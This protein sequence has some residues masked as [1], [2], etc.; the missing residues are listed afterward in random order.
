MKIFKY[1][2]G[3]MSIYH[4]VHFW[5][6]LKMLLIIMVSWPLT[7][8]AESDASVAAVRYTLA[9]GH[10]LRPTVKLPGTVK[11]RH[12]SIIASVSQSAQE[13]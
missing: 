8:M 11:S 7:V 1:S 10:T 13:S 5:N 9:I 2:K 3:A 12:R 6:T 4:R